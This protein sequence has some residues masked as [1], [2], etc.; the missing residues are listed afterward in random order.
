MKINSKLKKFIT[1][2]FIVSVISLLGG[3]SGHLLV[4]N[5]WAF[6]V[7]FFIVQYIVFFAISTIIE[8]Y[9]IE[10]T[11]QKE[12]DKLENLSTILNCAYCNQQNIMTFLPENNNR[13]EFTCENCKK[14]NLVT[15]QF[16]V[17]RI[18]E[19]VSMPKVTGIPLEDVQH[20]K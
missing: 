14:K 1:S 17:A 7:L 10:K 5:F 15:M 8:S 19:P 4:S 9:F 6:F 12:L 3:I 13:V 16:I 11:K 20:E 18:T 2:T